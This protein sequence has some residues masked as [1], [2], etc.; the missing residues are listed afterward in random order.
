MNASFFL[1][2]VVNMDICRDKR[3]VSFFALKSIIAG[4]RD[5]C[6]HL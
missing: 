4:V 6:I 1:L 2:C 5:G 3:G